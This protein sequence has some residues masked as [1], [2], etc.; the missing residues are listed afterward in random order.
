MKKFIA[1][2][3]S[4]ISISCFA[5]NEDDVLVSKIETGGDILL[6]DGECPLSGS[7]GAKISLIVTT[8]N[9]IAGCW[10]VYE[11]NVYAIWLPPGMDPVKSKY[12]P[13]IFRLEKIL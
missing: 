13:T 5:M 11:K 7:K 9:V 12:D 2:I 1:T 8:N 4:F 10:F 3:L 6:F